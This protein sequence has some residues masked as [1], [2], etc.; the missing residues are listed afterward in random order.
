MELEITKIGDTITNT[1]SFLG[2]DNSCMEA[3]M[4]GVMI[5]ISERIYN[6]IKRNKKTAS[7]F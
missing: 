3:A 2:S 6:K 5:V 4:V 7:A 1:G